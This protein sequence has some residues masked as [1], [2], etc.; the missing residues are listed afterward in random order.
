M[1]SM[2]MSW[3][4]TFALSRRAHSRPSMT[5]MLESSTTTS[6]GQASIA[7]IGVTRSAECSVA[8]MSSV[9]MV[10]IP[11]G[12]KKRLTSGQSEDCNTFEALVL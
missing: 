7:P 12:L 2:G 6:G 5:G 8:G 3:V 4:A 11:S 10:V 1:I 9:C